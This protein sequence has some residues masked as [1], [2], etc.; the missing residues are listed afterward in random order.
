MRVILRIFVGLIALLAVSA[1]AA[2]SPD[3][4]SWLRLGAALSI[5]LEDQGCGD[6]W[7]RALWRDRRG[8]GWWAPCVPNWR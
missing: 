5:G 8:E 4:E 3:Q 1:Q 2:P 6:G 7:H